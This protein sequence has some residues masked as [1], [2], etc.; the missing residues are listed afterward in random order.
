MKQLVFL[1]EKWRYSRYKLHLDM[2]SLEIYDEH[3]SELLNLEKKTGVILPNSPTQKIGF[4]SDEFEHVNRII[5]MLSLNSINT[6]EDLDKWEK[7]LK[8]VIT[9]EIDIEYVCEWKIDGLSL[10][11]EYKNNK[12]ETISSRGDGYV[13]EDL[14]FNKE[15]IKNI[16]FFSDIKNLEVRGEVYIKRSCFLELNDELKK[17]GDPIFSNPRSAASG[18]IQNLSPPP[19]RR[20]FF[21]AYTLFGKKINS[22]VE[23]LEE[24][25]KMG[26][27]VS[28]FVLCRGLEDVKKI[29]N[30]WKEQRENTEFAND[31]VVVKLNSYCFHDKLGRTST[32]PNW[33]IAYKFPSSTVYSKITGIDIKVTKS[34]RISYVAN[35]KPVFLLGSLIKRVTLHNYNFISAKN[36]NIGDEIVIK[37]SGD[38][39]PQISQVIKLVDGI[40]IPTQT[41]PSCNNHLFWDKKKSYQSCN[42]DDCSEKK[43]S[44]L[45]FFASKNGMNIKNVSYKLIKKLYFH[46]VVKEPEDFYL[47][48]SDDLLAIDGVKEKTIKNILNSINLSKNSPLFC[49]L[50]S[51]SIPGLSKTKSRYLFNFYYDF[52]DF[53]KDLYDPSSEKIKKI[54]GEKAFK[55][56]KLFLSD[57]KK[58]KTFFFLKNRL[59][60]I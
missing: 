6:F 27:F 7:S 39:I 28:P 42:N 5:P 17:K 51:L 8:K 9:N 14:T 43:I 31:G 41:C 58:R 60:V 33:E 20:L 36:I 52:N 1:L 48:K 25:K 13:G 21:C 32:F 53:I 37:K 47:L 30:I 56:I 12:L 54:V 3:F 38:I 59:K 15:L 22:Q 57:P 44:Y 4:I 18:T 55:E 24:L 40:W 19:G 23:C 49:Q 16:P 26:F 29:I 35:L 11:I 2:V 34:G 45:T 50:S 10:S 46:G